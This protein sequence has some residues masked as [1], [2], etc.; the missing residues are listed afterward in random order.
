[1]Q[2]GEGERVLYCYKNVNK[3]WLHKNNAYYTTTKITHSIII[4]LF[5]LHTT[6]NVHTSTNEEFSVGYFNL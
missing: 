2:F 5:V 3:E 6:P 4:L 1:M